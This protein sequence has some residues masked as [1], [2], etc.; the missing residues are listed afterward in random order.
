[1]DELVVVTYPEPLELEARA[2]ES[3]TAPEGNVALAYYHAG[4]VVARGV[5]TVDAVPAIHGLLREPVSLA[6][7]ATVDEERNISA[8]VCLV[9]PFDPGRFSEEDDGAEPWRASIPEPP[10][11]LGSGYGG[12]AEPDSSGERPRLALLPIGNVVRGAH[13]R[14]HDDVAAD[15]REMLDNL[16]SG[17]AR[18]AVRKAIDDL[19]DSI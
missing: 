17:R 3:E 16:V 6:L 9:L 4:H 19:L 7:A 5:V 10:A 13:D 8:R 18:D 1:V 11:G 14:Q 12:V 2:L 15:V